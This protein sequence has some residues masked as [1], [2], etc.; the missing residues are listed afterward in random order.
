MTSVSSEAGLDT[1]VQR[2]AE[3]FVRRHLAKALGGR[4]G[5]LEAGVPTAAFTVLFLTTHH[6]PVA[7]GGGAAL[8]A[9][10]LLV[11]LV[12]RSTVQYVLN[13][14]AGI[15]IGTFFVYLAA[16]HGGSADEQ[17]LAYFLPGILLSL[18]Y[19]IGTTLTV[20][21]RWPLI[22]F[23]IGG[24]LGDP[25]GWRRTP[26]IVAVCNR[27]T[28]CLAVPYVLRVVAEGPLYLAGHQHWM[29]ADVAVSALGVTKIVLGWPLQLA[30]FGAMGLVLG[31]SH[32]PLDLDPEAEGVSAA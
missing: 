15:A 8:T 21:V 17:A 31:R 9:V 7:I 29:P 22:G 18:A 14:A 24:V 30:A 3:E 19:A 10:G 1:D 16:R 27:L 20:V 13:A 4:R 25:I 12:H 11:R 32:T 26:G 5:M 28:L 23:L 2:T 6:L